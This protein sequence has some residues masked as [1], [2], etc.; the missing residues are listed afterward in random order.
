MAGRPLHILIV[1]D[2]DA[3]RAAVCRL[4]MQTGLDIIT[5]EASSIEG[6]VSRLLEG[7]IDCAV[8]EYHLG[9]GTAPELLARARERVSGF[10][11]PSVFVAGPESEK[12][13]G[14]ALK[15][16]INDYLSKD[17]LDAK[18][19]G[20]AIRTAVAEHKFALADSRY[21]EALAHRSLHDEL[22]SMPNRRLFLDRL[23]ERIG[24]ARRSNET[25][26][27]MMLDLDM[28]KSINDTLGHAA[29]D[30]VLQIIGERLL[31]IARRTDTY[32][33]LGSDEFSILVGGTIDG[34]IVVA[35]KIADAVAEPIEYE[36]RVIKVD[37]S[38]GIA[39]YPQH[40]RD[41]KLLMAH[42]DQAMHASKQSARRFSVYNG[43]DAA[44]LHEGSRISMEIP[45]LAQPE[46]VVLHYQPKYRLG[47][48]AMIGVEA[49]AR[50]QHSVLGNVPP[51]KFIP[52][53]ERS[54]FI[55]AFTDIVFNQA[56]AQAAAW[57]AAGHRMKM[58]VNVSVQSLDRVGFVPHITEMLERYALP[59]E[60]LIIEIT[61]TASL[62][63]Y[64]RS[65]KILRLLAEHGVG[66]SIDDFG[67]GYTSIRYLRD[68]PV[69]ELKI[70]R[71]FVRSVADGQRDYSIVSGIVRLAQG[72]GA[73]TVAEGIESVE[74]LRALS[75]VG[76]D[77]GQ[78]YYLARP[79]PAAEVTA[80]LATMRVGNASTSIAV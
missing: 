56:L 78:G 46:Q 76:C 27:V 44:P 45:R 67:T 50:W 29:G 18:T 42:A 1:D 21:R 8:L 39:S 33:R 24:M 11:I 54:K 5:H 72:I 48:G 66:I 71:L 36:E 23:D 47:D 74:T 13:A 17:K 16:G 37:A 22:T 19:L 30:F 51:D 77:F 62:V 26:A 43:P 28:F 69:S 57:R 10:S 35:Q 15:L 25:F 32:A 58:S 70:D 34:A 79:E 64:D 61:E 68:F 12:A 80:R 20:Q 2:D 52:I 49:L 14:K 59:P 38:I 3:A 55:F 41:A 4:S 53:L 9:D 63:S 7:G 60:E 65:A 6:G 73:S 40:G 75:D 31:S